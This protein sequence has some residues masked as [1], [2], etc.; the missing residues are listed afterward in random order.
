M[1][2]KEA[3]A[4]G[5]TMKREKGVSVYISYLLRHKPGDIGLEMD[6]HGWVRVDMLIDGINKQGRYTL[7]REQLEEI[8]KNDNKGRY[9]FDTDHSRIKA[10]QGHSI[11][12]I[13]P[14]LEFPDTPEFLYHGTTT[15]AAEKIFRSGAISKMSRHA[16][17]MQ[18]DPRK[19]W[20]SAA[21]WKLTPVV[22]KIHAAKMSR[23]GF[24]FGKTEND[25]WCTESVPVEY[26]VGQ[27]F[28]MEP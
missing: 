8:V 5:E 13:V 1:D 9:R 21:R 20:Q 17:H 3:D 23:E 7:D 6:L 18:A 4:G 12:G 2:Q 24:I 19:A 28:D 10:C 22:L 16:V 26:I 11:P 25:V 14:E 15:I 27:I